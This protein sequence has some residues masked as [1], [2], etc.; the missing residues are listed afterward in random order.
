MFYGS[1]AAVFWLWF[2]GDP[3]LCLDLPCSES[4]LC[5]AFLSLFAYTF[6]FRSSFYRP[7]KLA[8]CFVSMHEQLENR[9]KWQAVKQQLS[10]TE[11]VCFVLFLVRANVALVDCGN[12]IQV[13]ISCQ[14]SHKMMQI[15]HLQTDPELGAMGKKDWLRK[16]DSGSCLAFFQVIPQ[17]AIW[18]QV[19][20]C[21]LQNIF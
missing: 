12:S 9:A 19:S 1:L 3:W 10:L 4:S 7:F 17:S 18:S 20:I 5:S 2:G 21:D 14:D 6:M 13:K 16:S 8:Q 11:Q 15:F